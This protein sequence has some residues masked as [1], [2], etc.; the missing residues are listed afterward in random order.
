MVL[1]HSLAAVLTLLI[2]LTLLAQQDRNPVGEKRAEPLV[3]AVVPLIRSEDPLRP[4]VPDLALPQTGQASQTAL[5][6]QQRLIQEVDP[7]GV[8]TDEERNRRM[9][10]A[11]LRYG[12]EWTGR[13]S[14]PRATPPG[15]L[16]DQPIPRFLDSMTETELLRR[17]NLTT[18]QTAAL[19]T[20]TALSQLPQQDLY[21]LGL[22]AQGRSELQQYQP[23][24]QDRLN[25]ILNQQSLRSRDLP[26]PLVNP[27]RYQP[28][29]YMRPLR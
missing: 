11:L 16:V 9:Q 2:P 28:N 14:A 26:M 13:T 5:L 8:L 3:P 22:N 1:R 27:Y 4:R 10:A 25:Q 19:R 23:P 17:Y 20:A 7:H 6:L 29:G 18:Q 15:Y 24:A 21:R 12:P